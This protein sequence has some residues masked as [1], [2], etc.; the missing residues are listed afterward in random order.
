MLEAALRADVKS[1]SR[2]GLL[3]LL[4]AA[5]APSAY[6]AWRWRSMPQLGLYHDDSLYWVSAKSLAQGHGYRIAS[7]PGEPAQTKYP[8]LFPAIL[9]LVW[10][11]CPSFPANLPFAAMTV[12]IAFPAYVLILW[13]VFRQ[14]G[15]TTGVASAL[16]VVGAWNPFAV[17][18]SCSLMAE[19]L[20]MTLLLGCL[21]L[22]ERGSV[23]AG[24]VAGLAFLVKTAALPLLVT[25]PICFV[26]RRQYRRAVVFV[27]TMLPTVAAWQLWVAW[28]ASPGQDLVT[29]YYT[30]YIGFRRYNVG[31]LDLPVVLW[32][33]F[34]ALLRSTGNLLIFDEPVGGWRHLER[35]VAIG[36]MAG[37]WR[38]ARRSRCLQLPLATAAMALI[39]LLW[40]YPPDPRLALPL[41][42]L[43]LGGLW[44][45]AGHLVKALGAAWRRP[46]IAER[47]LAAVAGLV[48]AV[49]VL[50]VSAGHAYGDWVFIPRVLTA[51]A[52]DLASARP[53]YA[54]V[55]GHTR[56]ESNLYGY[57]DPMIYLY[58]GR[59]ACSLPIPTKYYYYND[60]EGIDR[61]LR[62]LPAFSTQQK[63]EYVFL[64]A[65]DFYRDLHG[66]G[67]AVTRQT[68][69]QSA[70][71]ERVYDRSGVELFRRVSE[72]KP[73]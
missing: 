38:L 21:Y 46:A 43:L 45:E 37:A 59:H 63:I 41:Y 2:L 1:V 5:L 19:I 32:H 47:M 4:L 40:H 58:T 51:Y 11:L 15:M 65:H 16:A 57:D 12:W 3:L 28:H 36:A 9:S 34:D 42:P 20:F 62:G 13:V 35:I 70:Y 17:L 53:A 23:W 22:A 8:P 14:L 6:Q 30:N 55:A 39:L 66:G 25:V 24:V 71:F 72:V 31:W 52:D 49:F 18:L 29:L 50:S 69:A 73:L 60:D 7:L 33:N 64:T 44:T 67:A 48:L 10:R 27:L 68:I 26:L 54:W 61:L 56:P